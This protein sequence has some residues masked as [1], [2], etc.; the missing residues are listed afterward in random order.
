MSIIDLQSVMNFTFTTRKPPDGTWGSV[1]ENGEWNGIMRELVDE[2]ADISKSLDS[3]SKDCKT[4][5][6]FLAVSDFTFALIR[7]QA[8]SFTHSLS[9]VH[10]RIFLK[11]T[12]GKF[13]LM[14]YVEPLTRLSWLVIGIFWLL[15]SPILYLTAK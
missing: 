3:L 8:V 13:N 9:R 12:D 2:K 7:A 6:G 15:C 4:D 5:T 14:A 10:H 11:R 1:N